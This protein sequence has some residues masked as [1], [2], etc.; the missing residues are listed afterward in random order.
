MPT[1]KT[2]VR[3]KTPV[4]ARLRP[5]DENGRARPIRVAGH[6]EVAFPLQ[7]SGLAWGTNRVTR[8]K[9]T[10]EDANNITVTM[11]ESDTRW[12][13]DHVLAAL[14]LNQSWEYD[15]ADDDVGKL[16]I[17]GPANGDS[18]EYLIQAGHDQGAT[19]NHFL[20]QANAISD[21]YN[22]FPTIYEDITQHPEN[23]GE[24]ITFVPTNNKSSVEG[25]GDFVKARRPNDQ[26]FLK[27]A[28]GLKG[29]TFFGKLGVLTP[30]KTE[31][32]HHGV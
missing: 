24:V 5:L 23:S 11:I 9:M 25:L 10:I 18:D 12:M 16:T 28:V 8:E 31:E 14:F 2:K 4:A 17:K 19:D 6:Y 32:G 27:V 7:S 21:T 29:M 13:R 22:P 15:D 26:A 1:T 20:A 30:T 3:F